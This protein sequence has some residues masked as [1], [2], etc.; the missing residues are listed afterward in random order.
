MPDTGP[1]GT[2]EHVGREGPV[3]ANQLTGERAGLVQTNAIGDAT[4]A[5]FS[6]APYIP[7]LPPQARPGKEPNIC[8]F[9]DC[10][11]WAKKDSMW[12]RWHQ[13]AGP[14]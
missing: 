2:T 7:P 8:L 9:G 4:H 5:L 12:C 1:Y 14:T 3:T 10:Q 11:A 13:M 6:T